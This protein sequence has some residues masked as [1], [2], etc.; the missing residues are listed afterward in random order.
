MLLNKKKIMDISNA[1]SHFS[2]Y[3]TIRKNILLFI[4]KVIVLD[5]IFYVLVISEIN[6]NL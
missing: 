2:N 4:I 5:Q 1:L 6:F 3:E